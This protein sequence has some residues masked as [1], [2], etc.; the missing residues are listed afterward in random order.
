MAEVRS[1]PSERTGRVWQLAAIAGIGGLVAFLTVNRLGASDVCGSNEAVEAIALRQ[2]VEHGQWLF[3]LD[4]GAEPMYK[5][6]LFH[7]TA[8]ALDRLLGIKHV[9]PFNLRL[10][11]ALYGVGGALLTTGFAF[12]RLGLEGAVVSGLALAASYEYVSQGRIGRVNMTLTFFEMLSLVSFLA[13]LEAA[14]SFEVRR[15][16]LRY[17]L[18]ASLG[19]GVLAKGPVGLLMPGIAIGVFL[20][21]EGRWTDLRRLFTP[22]S[23]L[24]TF[25]VASSWY[26]ACL[27]GRQFGLL[28]RQ[29]GSENLGRFFGSLGRMSAWY[30]VQP[31]LLNAG[32]LSLVVPVIV[33]T[34]LVQ[35]RSPH[36]RRVGLARGDAPADRMARLLAI[37][38]VVTVIFFELA[39][40][41][42][43]SYLL[44]LSPASGLLIAWWVYRYGVPR[45]G[46]I[47]PRATI[48]TCAAL[49]VANFFFIP[50]REV[51]ECGAVLTPGETMRWPFRGR[52]TT[53]Q[54]R[55][56]QA[57]SYRQLAAETNRA[58]GKDG[59]LFVY[60]F[61][62]SIEPLVFYLD[63]NVVALTGP[64]GSAPPGYILVP[65]GVWAGFSG[66]RSRFAELLAVPHGEG[67]IVL[68]H[69]N[70][71]GGKSGS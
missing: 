31:L 29:L 13:W 61:D 59:S 27:L 10:T 30:Y 51:R 26:L 44:P 62:R 7:W 43:K 34:A 41:K 5:P 4:N 57:D 17:L 12:A 15:N 54:I 46:R 25:S 69:S 55:S 18:A 33:G 53:E 40:Y 35:Y 39:A 48:A 42:R 24:V 68:L 20:F 32:P 66:S 71:A 9:T 19:L 2:M 11:S 38:W 65:G 21:L 22:L 67:A 58:V 52:Q 50:W 64:L 28:A 1:A 36:N 63:R 49:V 16:A 47:V 6:P 14:E 3:P 60:G 56:R 37:F 8:S 45:F 23:A 70:S